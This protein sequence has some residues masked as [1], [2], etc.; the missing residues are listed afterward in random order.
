MYNNVMLP[1]HR[2]GKLSAPQGAV[3][4]RV[5]V[6]PNAG[7]VVH[8]PTGR[9]TFAE[10]L[11]ERF[12]C[13]PEDYL[14]VALKQCLHIQARIWFSL[15]PTGLGEA[16]VELLEETGAATTAKELQG[17]LREYCHRLELSGGFAAKRLK[18]RVSCG[19]LQKLWK[20][21]MRGET[22]SVGVSAN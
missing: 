12:G 14:Q 19:R 1:R 13:A 9:K 20:R 17:L 8:L 2:H 11:C 15:F 21:A 3:R 6:K 5:L 4:G 18:L 7:N 10:G 22:A 16:D